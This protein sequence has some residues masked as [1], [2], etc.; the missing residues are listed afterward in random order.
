MSDDTT[1]PPPE[2]QPPTPPPPSGYGVP[3]APPV[4]PGYGAP[5]AGAAGY[6]AVD[7]IKYGWEKFSKK[8]AEL[9]V[10]GLIFLLCVI[11]VEV[12]AYLVMNA[13]LLGT[14]DCTRTIFGTQVEA[15]C[16]P[17]FFTTLIGQALI[18]LAASVVVSALGAGLIKS[19]L[20][21]VDGL[22][23]NVGD[24]FGYA[25]KPAVLTTAA[26][27]GV[28]TFIGTVACI[29]PGIIFGFVTAFAMFFVVDK[30]MA[31][32]DAIKASISFMTAN[33]GSTL[34]FYLLGIATMIVGLI[35]CGIGVFVAAPVVAI[36]A[37]YTF[38]T[39]HNEPVTPVA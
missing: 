32:V 6:S 3:P 22:E 2:S 11:A 17:S 23:V 21:V 35:A 8:P 26:L 9:L 39:L 15:Q 28:G 16:S 30:E 20:N 38:R 7:A 1:P 25:T 18:S 29:V 36:A 33:L 12:V 5:P 4:P 19:A 34:V 24:I 31:P 13:T 27:I 37:A 10:P 14:H